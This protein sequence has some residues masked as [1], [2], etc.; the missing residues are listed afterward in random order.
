MSIQKVPNTLG[1][2]DFIDNGV[3]VFSMDAD[4]GG[5][6]APSTYVRHFDDFLGDTPDARYSGAKG[7][8]A[9]AVVPTIT[10]ANGGWVRSTSGDTATVAESAVVL[11]HELNWKAGNGGLYLE[12]RIKPVTS[13]ADVAYFVGFTDVLATTTLEIPITLSGTTLTTTATDAVGFVY[14]TAATNDFWHLQGVK[15]DTDTAVLNSSV[16]P[17]ADTAAILAIEVS[18]A[19]TA[20]FYINGVKVGA[21]AN[22]VTTTVALTPVISV[23]ARATTSKSI[24]VDYLLVTSKRA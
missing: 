8:D 17:A 13:V 19:G 1:G 23:M 4:K 22:A 18:T 21:A 24:D 2:L 9:Q 12:A 14:D 5:Y 15:A 7:S 6:S 16:A 3:K 20:T 11:T 10:S